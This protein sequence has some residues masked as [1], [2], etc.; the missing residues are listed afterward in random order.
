MLKKIIELNQLLH[1]NK[2]E[3]IAQCE[4]EYLN[5]IISDVIDLCILDSQIITSRSN[6]YIKIASK[7][8]NV[9]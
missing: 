1:S 3:F 8:R 7:S 4:N 6:Q 5:K 2:Y 9:Q